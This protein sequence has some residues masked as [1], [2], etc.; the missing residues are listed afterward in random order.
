MAH[1]QRNFWT[2]IWI[3]RLSVVSVSLLATWF[4]YL[5]VA[6]FLLGLVGYGQTSWIPFATFELH[7]SNRFVRQIAAQALGTIGPKAAST[8]PELIASLQHDTWNVAADSACALG[9]ILARNANGGKEPDPNAIAALIQALNH[10]NGEVRRY[11]AYAISLIGPQA[12]AAT[13]RLTQLLSDPHMGSTAAEALG[14]MGVAGQSA[15]QPMTALLSDP[16]WSVK[17]ETILALSRLGPLPD[18]TI[19]AI[20]NCRSDSD[21]HVRDAAKSVLA[22][23]DA[24]Q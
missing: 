22:I 19:S 11:A 21:E 16:D 9:N 8:V 6:I 17:L 5:V 14:E 12:A 24:T 2:N 3:I 4:V 10:S 7:S 15:I 20:R 18:K 23:L 13:P 1:N